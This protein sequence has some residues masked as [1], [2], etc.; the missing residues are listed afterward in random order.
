MKK[1]HFGTKTASIRTIALLLLLWAAVSFTAAAEP[2]KIPRSNGSVKSTAPGDWPQA[3][4]NAAHTGK[5]RFETQLNPRNVPNLTQLWA[6]PV[7]VFGLY[8]S[9][10]VS[11]GKVYIGSGDFTESHMYAFDALTGATLWVGAQQSHFF[12]NSAAVGHGLVFATAYVSPLIAYDADTGEIAWTADLSTARAAPVLNGSV[13]YVAG[14]GGQLYA[15]DARTGSVL[16]STPEECCIEDYTP[17]VSGDRLFQNR[18]DS[19][20]TAYDAQT[21]EELWHKSYG[22]IV[23]SLTAANQK[24]FVPA[25]P[26]IVALDQATGNVVWSAPRDNS[27]YGALAVGN[28]LLFVPQVSGLKA[29]DLET[30][31]LVW[32]A[33]T[34]FGWTW[35]PA[36]ANG[37]VYASNLNGE[38]I[39][40]DA[41]DGTELW[42]VSVG[43][44]ANGAPAVANGVLYLPGPD[45]VLRAYSVPTR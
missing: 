1:S 24:L 11:N 25:D 39:A 5:N 22:G 3:F 20:V 44:C 34:T 7:G 26:N 40:L 23:G 17:T 38:W 33:P 29:F 8:T 43:C 10:V 28:G 31:T 30:G 6:S 42:S 12:L 16:W 15:L 4:F 18:S 13:L 19:I 35:G 2:H 9:P 21:G 14:S 45:N 27:I 37:V 41:R 32:T 36:V